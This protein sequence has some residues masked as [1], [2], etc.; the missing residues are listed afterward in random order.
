[1]VVVVVAVVVVV[2][3]TP[4]LSAAT[5]GVVAPQLSATLSGDQTNTN[6]EFSNSLGLPPLSLGANTVEWR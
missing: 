1:V 2:G 3:T 5:L 4:P 6:L